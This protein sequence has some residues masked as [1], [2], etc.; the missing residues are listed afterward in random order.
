MTDEWEPKTKTGKLVKEGKIASI[1]ELF[2]MNMRILEPEIVDVLLPKLEQEVLDIKLVQKQTDAGEK[3]KYKA[4]VAVGNRDGYVG[5]GAG[6]S[7]HVVSAIEAAVKRAKTNLSYVRRG[8]GSW[9]CACNDAHSLETV[10]E[11]KWG[12]VKI[13]MIPGPRGLGLVAGDIA[14][15][16][17][18]LAGVRDC[19]TRTFGETRTTLS[20]A[21]A[22][23]MCLKA[24]NKVVVPSVWKVT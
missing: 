4:I 2:S 17:L 19:W 15:T 8:C 1:E 23:F 21:G 9:E 14:K 5:L 11:G 7:V 16:I 22:T 20:M 10:I 12:S 24:T 3:S 13:L 18:R 6:K